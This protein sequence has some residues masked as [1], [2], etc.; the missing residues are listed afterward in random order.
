MRH[1]RKWN[2][3]SRSVRARSP[4]C[5]RCKENPSTEVHHVAPI[6]SGGSVF[7]P[8]N[9]MAVCQKCHFLIEKANSARWARA[10][11]TPEGGCTGDT[12]ARGTSHTNLGTRL[13]WTSK[14]R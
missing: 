3:L 12:Y 5:E 10:K 9:L 11:K 8:R 2:E 1:G 13:K 4:I 14:L 7:D 6:S